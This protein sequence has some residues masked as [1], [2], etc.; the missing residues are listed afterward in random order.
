MRV[1]RVDAVE[2]RVVAELIGEAVEADVDRRRAH[3]FGRNAFAV[4][5]VAIGI[6]PVDVADAADEVGETERETQREH[7]VHA[8]SEVQR[9]YRR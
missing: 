2:R 3:G 4:V 7:P 8:P 1:R 6:D 9:I 5:T